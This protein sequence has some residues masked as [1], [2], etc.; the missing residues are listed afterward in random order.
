M[1]VTGPPKPAYGTKV[2]ARFFQK[3]LLTLLTLPLP[4]RFCHIHI[5]MRLFASCAAWPTGSGHD[6]VLLLGPSG[7][8]KSDFCAR[9]LHEGWALVADDQVEIH[10]GIASAPVALA[11]LLE[12]RGLGIFRLPHI[13]APLRLAVN[14][15]TQITRLPA[16]ATHAPTGLPLVTID[17]YKPGATARATMAL[18]A[19]CGRLTQH[20]GAFAA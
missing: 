10:E 1:A 16:P 15:G 12:L 5:T 20:T 7:A 17:P 8:G 4:P 18:G 11:G 9:L 19:A 2:F 6:A 3:A 14:L 13:A